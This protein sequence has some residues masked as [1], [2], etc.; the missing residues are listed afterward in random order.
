VR[1]GKE[2]GLRPI[3]SRAGSGACKGKVEEIQRKCRDNKRTQAVQQE[4]E[5]VLRCKTLGADT[6]GHWRVPS[7]SPIITRGI[8]KKS[9]SSLHP[10]I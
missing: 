5:F 8:T 6:E 1:L 4:P 10:Q 9:I 3:S 2:E 7:F